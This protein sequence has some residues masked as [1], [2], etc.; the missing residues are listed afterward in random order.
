MKKLL[1]CFIVFTLL[2]ASFALKTEA[3]C[4]SRLNQSKCSQSQNITI[5]N[6]Y[7]TIELPKELNGVYE[8]KVKKDSVELYHKESKKQALE[9][10][11]LG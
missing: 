8:S 1:L 6:K 10:L 5:K 2:I 9:V 4:F 7:F 3:K 11:P